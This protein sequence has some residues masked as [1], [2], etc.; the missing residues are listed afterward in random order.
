MAGAEDSGIPE[1]MNE[2]FVPTFGPPKFRTFIGLLF[3]PYTCMVLSFTLIGSLLAGQIFYD[4]L[5]AIVIIYFLGLGVA[6]H[7]LDALGSKGIKPWGTIFSKT[8][9]WLMAL[10]ALIIAYG[11][12]CFYMIRYV[13]LL[14]IIAILEGFFVFAYNLEWFGGMFHTDKW[15]AFSWGVLPVLAG[16]IMQTNRVSLSALVLSA[17]MG[18]FSFLEIKVS[19][20]YKELKRRLPELSFGDLVLLERYETIL[21]CISFGV[22]FLGIGLLLWRSLG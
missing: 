5:L 15:F 9:L 8:A 16:Y 7:A 6:A 10:L 12:G 13:P 22:I 1:R 21:K 3:L 2:W 17:S 14:W 4:R 19:R 11:I 18:L 20:P